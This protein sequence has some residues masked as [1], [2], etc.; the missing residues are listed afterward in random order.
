MAFKI[1]FISLLLFSLA[2]AL[3]DS[4]HVL[5][6]KN[7]DFPRVLSEFENIFVKFYAPW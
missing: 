1:V 5:T 6:L 4:S 3:E 2:L 7:E